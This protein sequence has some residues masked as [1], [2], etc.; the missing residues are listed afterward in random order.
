[1]ST[2]TTL[3]KMYSNYGATSSIIPYIDWV[4]V[5]FNG[6]KGVGLHIYETIDSL[7]DYDKF[8]RKFDRIIEAEESFQDLD[9]AVK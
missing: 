9:H 8:E 7:E 3:E 4:I 6:Y 2:S 1:M 5:A